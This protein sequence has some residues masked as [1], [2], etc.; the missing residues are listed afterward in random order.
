MN[1]NEIRLLDIMGYEDINIRTPIIIAN[2][3]PEFLISVDKGNNIYRIN[4]QRIY[5]VIQEK[6]E[7]IYQFIP[8]GYVKLDTVAPKQINILLANTRLIPHTKTFER[9][10]NSDEWYGVI[11]KGDNI[12][13]TIGTI[14]S[15]TRPQMEVPVFLPKFMKKYDPDTDID[16]MIYSHPGYGSFTLNKYAFDLDNKNIR[17]IDS[18][19]SL[20]KMFIP[21]TPHDISNAAGKEEEFNKRVYYTAQGTITGSSN[22]VPPTD[23]MNKMTLNECNSIDVSANDDGTLSLNEAISE[24]PVIGFEDNKR[25]HKKNKYIVLKEK[26]EPWFLNESIVGDAVRVADP[27]KVTGTNDSLEKGMGTVYG[28]T[29]EI[30]MKFKSDCKTDNIIGY[31]RQDKYN[32]C[33][34]SD[35]IEGFDDRG[36]RESACKSDGDYNNYIITFMCVF[37]LILLYF[38][39]SR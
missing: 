19:G 10:K 21:T 28:D 27:H 6:V 26:D 29:D 35:S 36:F 13:R 3:G 14:K 7:Y 23:N 30:N 5:N 15:K 11:R 9:I 22:C 12:A 2:I 37:I 8:V 24:Y 18:S 38:R 17:M 1:S 39:K 25:I 32:K 4:T 20:R 34:G 31:S 16:F 33:L